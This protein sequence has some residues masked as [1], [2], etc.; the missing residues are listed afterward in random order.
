M[1]QRHQSQR[2]SA[3][4]PFII[5]LLL[6]LGF[7]YAWFQEKDQRQQAEETAKV[8]TIDAAAANRVAQ[9]YVDYA[10]EMSQEIGWN[11]Q[12]ATDVTK[13]IP[14]ND[15]DVK[16]KI[17]Q[18][19]RRLAGEAYFTNLEKLRAHLKPE[20]TIDGAPGLL[21]YLLRE[22]TIQIRG[23]LRTAQAEGV[24]ETPVEFD[25]MSTEF[26]QKI[27]EINALEIPVAPRPVVDADDEADQARYE[28]E[29][30]A[31][32][33]AVGEWESQVSE[34]MSM[35]GWKEYKQIIKGPTK[36]D[37]DSVRTVVLKFFAQPPTGKVTIQDLLGYP[38]PVIEA[39]K[40]E[41]RA[42][43]E[44]DTAVIDRVRQEVASHQASIGDLN[45]Q[46]AEEQDRH[47]QDVE[48][49]RGELSTA[50]ETAEQNRV[51]ATTAKQDLAREKDDKQTAISAREARIAALENRIRI[52][53]EK[54]DL[55]I[56]RDDPDGRILTVS[57]GMRTAM[58]D[59]GTTDKVYPGLKFNV[60]RIGR[61]GIRT[62]KGQVMVTRVLGPNAAKVTILTEAD[63][64]RP[65][66]GGD[67]LSNP[68]FSPRE[69]IHI[70]LAGELERYPI[71]IARDRL[72]KMNVVI[73]KAVNADT[74]YIIVPN[75]ME[76]PATTGDEGDDED[77]GDGE[78]ASGAQSE[79]ERVQALAREF[80]ATVMTERMLNEFLDY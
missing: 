54:R 34:L 28:S 14:E 64:R 69:T 21:G 80:G 3:N 32:E 56:R 65:V 55:E 38:K 44:E 62:L 60:S 9:R 72:A 47:T 58:I 40:A 52:D 13:D 78:A 53:K 30:V 70:Y 10:R 77:E 50:N 39:F 76:A 26:R 79:Y 1:R 41:F 35:D 25:W 8:A 6:L 5:A 33:S 29:R 61:G 68:F 63:A 45:T 57:P 7:V 20:G 17:D 71:G 51:E 2:G 46:L 59:L 43:K 11:D 27:A 22:A 66:L 67:L 74:D 31:Y 24:E 75:T 36:F 16:A 48:Q 19:A 37:P 42:N 4:W 73:D 15:A 23:D 18:M 12:I 49:L